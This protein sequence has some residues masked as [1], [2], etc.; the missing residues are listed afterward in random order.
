MRNDFNRIYGLALKIVCRL[1]ALPQAATIGTVNH[2][3]KTF[4]A[5]MAFAVALAV[6]AA[7]Y[8][9][10]PASGV[11]PPVPSTVDSI[12]PGELRMHL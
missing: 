12:T 10:S 3:F 9:A 4:P 1:Y 6:S 2:R 5:K 8:A 11:L 7:L